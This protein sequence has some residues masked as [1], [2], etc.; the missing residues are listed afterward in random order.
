MGWTP[1]FGTIASFY[2][3]FPSLI[4]NGSTFMRVSVGIYKS[5]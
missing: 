1:T 5:N 3:V 2:P 4:Q